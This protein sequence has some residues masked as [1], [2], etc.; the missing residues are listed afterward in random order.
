VTK[1]GTGLRDVGG[2]PGDGAEAWIG[3]GE[4]PEVTCNDADDGGVDDVRDGDEKLASSS[5][6]PGKRKRPR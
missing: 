2:R 3:A 4:T 6:R 5:L 1:K